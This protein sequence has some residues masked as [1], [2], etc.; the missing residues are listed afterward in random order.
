LKMCIWK[1]FYP[2]IFVVVA[3]SLC[4]STNVDRRTKEFIKLLLENIEV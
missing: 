2:F 3:T 1:S 4:Y